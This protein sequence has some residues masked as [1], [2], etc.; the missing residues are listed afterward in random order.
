[1]RGPPSGTHRAQRLAGTGIPCSSSVS[2]AQQ[3]LGKHALLRE[4]PPISWSPTCKFTRKKVAV[5]VNTLAAA[6][7]AATRY[8]VPAQ[9]GQ[10][11]ASVM[12]SASASAAP[13]MPC[14][15]ICA[16]AASRATQPGGAACSLTSTWA[17]RVVACVSDG[18]VGDD[19]PAQGTIRATCRPHNACWSAPQ[20][21]AHPTSS[22]AKWTPSATLDSS[23]SAAA[24]GA[25]SVTVFNRQA[26]CAHGS[27][28]SDL[29]RGVL[30]RH[31]CPGKACPWVR[32]SGL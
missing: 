29:Q 11:P 3:H 30:V 26:G 14:S 6:S 27:R 5:R 20:Q 23:G 7:A 22:E 17:H 28:C 21:Q 25:H 12:P 10:Q 19:G 18:A 4:A 2:L 16:R 15:A 8:R 24:A 32:C 13:A 9:A 1:M 31:L